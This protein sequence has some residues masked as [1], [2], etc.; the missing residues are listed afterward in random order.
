M[1][2][3]N[4]SNCLHPMPTLYDI[5]KYLY[6]NEFVP[7]PM[8]NYALYGLNMLGCDSIIQYEDDI[9]MFWAFESRTNNTI[10]YNKD[11]KPLTI[12]LYDSDL[13]IQ[14]MTVKTF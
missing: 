10:Y 8:G 6:M 14:R 3:V 4:L 13:K 2:G 12:N 1:S 5:Q 11:R 7:H 9:W